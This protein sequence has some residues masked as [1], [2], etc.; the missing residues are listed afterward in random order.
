MQLGLQR[1]PER[2]VVRIVVVML[3][4]HAVDHDVAVGVL[5]GDIGFQRDPDPHLQIRNILVAL[6]LGANLAD[7]VDEEAASTS[8]QV[9][10]LMTAWLTAELDRVWLIGELAWRSAQREGRRTRGAPITADL[11]DVLAGR[12][13]C[14]SG[15]ELHAD[16]ELRRA[17]AQ[18]RDAVRADER[19]LPELLHHPE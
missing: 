13:R 9:G 11:E 10:V 12:R 8:R 14:R 5:P 7:T 1:L 2:D 15:G 17:L 4:G 16:D 6:S 19:V 3:V 18:A